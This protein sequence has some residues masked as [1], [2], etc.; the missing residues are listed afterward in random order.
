MKV[1]ELMVI[2]KLHDAD[3]EIDIV[4]EADDEY[5]CLKIWAHPETPD[6]DEL[7]PEIIFDG[8]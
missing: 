2:L 3:A 8:R 1:H 6:K 5:P 4:Q 7:N